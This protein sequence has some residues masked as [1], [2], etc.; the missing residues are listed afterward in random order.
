MNLCRCRRSWPRHCCVGWLML[1]L[2]G[3]ASSQPGPLISAP[4]NH[5]A[6]RLAA[7]FAPPPAESAA[8]DSATN[9]P[10]PGL[11]NAP[12][13]PAMIPA[14]GRPAIDSDQYII[15]TS[16]TV[17]LKVF[18][19]EALNARARVA[20]DGTVLLPLLGAVKV[21]RLTIEEARQRIRDLLARD[22]LV[23]P[24]VLLTVSEVAKGRFTVLGQV[25]Q[26]GYYELPETGKLNL[27]QAISMAG[28]YTR[29]ANPARITI[30]RAI[31][32]RETVRQVDA[33]SMARGKNTPIEEIRPE[34]T[35]YVA[36]RVF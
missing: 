23:N 33:R 8:A 14:P 29:L 27:L 1:G 15:K 5:G 22:Y 16:D 6:V 30:K 10:L 18:Q 11:S 2:T 24:Q 35:I 13:A 34:D 21:E 12:T 25:Q 28:G 7:N 9:S 4:T 32:G 31:N 19:E 26:P 36:E 3:I 20:Q 17:E